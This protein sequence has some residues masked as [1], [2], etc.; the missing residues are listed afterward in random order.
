MRR[1]VLALA[2]ALAAAACAPD[3]GAEER[4]V[5]TLVYQQLSQPDLGAVVGPVVMESNFAL[6]DWTRGGLFGGRTLLRKDKGAWSMVLCGG[7]PLR[8]RPTIERAGVPDGT[9]GVLITKLLREESRLDVDRRNQLDK[10]RGARTDGKS[11]SCPEARS[12]T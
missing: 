8:K 1:A 5:R 10:F 7:E 2:L 3:T 4:K 11:V 9:A 12:G 6:V